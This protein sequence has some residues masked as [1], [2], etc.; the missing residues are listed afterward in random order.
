[1]GQWRELNEDEII[2]IKSMVADS[3]KD[4]DEHGYE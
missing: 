2:V 3:I 1:V 4:F